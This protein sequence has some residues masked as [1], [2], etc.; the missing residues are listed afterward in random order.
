M[1]KRRGCC[2]PIII[3]YLIVSCVGIVWVLNKLNTPE[4]DPN[5]SK[6]EKTHYSSEDLRIAF[7]YP[8]AWIKEVKNEDNSTNITLSSDENDSLVVNISGYLVPLSEENN[9]EDNPD[10]SITYLRDEYTY[11]SEEFK[12]VG[13]ID[14]KNLYISESGG[15][16]LQLLENNIY[17]G[18]VSSRPIELGES[19]YVYEI[20]GDLL[21]PDLAI[22]DFKMN[23]VRLEIQYTVN[24]QEVVD[25]WDDY[26]LEIKKI[27]SSVSVVE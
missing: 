10:C 17:T 14:N 12:S 18:I 7:D 16:T 1:N 22:Y 24:S 25:N 4:T 5:I 21:Y 6:N 11:K 19:Y 8:K 9:C 20:N 23:D 26:W 15:T 27:V 2:F 3:I 13:T